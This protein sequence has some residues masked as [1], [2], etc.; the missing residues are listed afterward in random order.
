MILL[1]L[2][3]VVLRIAEVGFATIVAAVNGKYLHDIS[4]FRTH[5]QEARFI[6][7]EV[8]AGLALVL[9]LVWLIPFSGSFTHW[10]V[11]LFISVCW[12]AAFGVLVNVSSIL[13][14]SHI[15]SPTPC[16]SFQTGRMILTSIRREIQYLNETG[17]CGYVFSWDVTLRGDN[18][19]GKFKAVI[20]FSFLSAIC[21][22]VSA[23]IGLI[24][25]RDHEHRYRRR[26]FYRSSV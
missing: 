3:S 14:H 7:T 2:A 8:V 23:F 24:W 11:D 5:W 21:W 12:F 18:P 16:P 20:A 10:P 13:R 1:D 22:L 26:A 4:D 15:P 25:V 19:C 9:A 6:Y 17:S